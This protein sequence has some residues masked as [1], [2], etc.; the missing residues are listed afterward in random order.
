MA[1]GEPPLTDLL[2]ELGVPFQRK[3]EAW[4]VEVGGAWATFGW[5][6]RDATLAGFLEYAEAPAAQRPS[7]C[8][9]NAEPGLAWY[10]AGDDE[11]AGPG[12]SCPAEDLD[13]TGLA[14][15]IGPPW[16]R[17]AGGAGRGRSVRTRRSPDVEAALE[18]LAVDSEEVV[19]APA[20][21]H[22]RAAD[23]AQRADARRGRGDW[24]SGCCR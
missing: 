22:R 4:L 15:A 19:I 18:E 5:V 23:R 14:L 6:P 2:Q 8:A 20:R 7:W 21:R 12:E 1:A 17:E 9:R 24:P 11:P 10:Q 13:R 16:R 3:G